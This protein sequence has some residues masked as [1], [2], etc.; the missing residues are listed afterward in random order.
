[1]FQI[2]LV[3]NEQVTM[4]AV[5]ARLVQREQVHRIH[6]DHQWQFPLMHLAITLWTLRPSQ[7]LIGIKK[8][9][10][11]RWLLPKLCHCLLFPLHHY[12]L[13]LLDESDG[14]LELTVL[15]RLVQRDHRRRA[16]SSGFGK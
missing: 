1:M 12:S 11:L 15:K 10:V 8:E 3:S 13:L 9:A 6:M 2:V 7:V 4:G 5:A 16:Y 14:L